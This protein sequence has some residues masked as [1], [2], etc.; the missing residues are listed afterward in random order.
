MT[1]LT[2]A[3]ESTFENRKNDWRIGAMTYQIFVDRFAPARDLSAKKHLY[4]SPK[5][6][7]DWSESP[8][9]E[10]PSD[11]SILWT[12]ELAFWGGDLNSLTHKLDY[13]ESLGMDVVYLN[14]IV[15]AQS[16]HK[17][18]AIDYFKIAPEYGD[19]DDLNQLTTELNKRDMHLILDGVFNH[20]GYQS[21]WFQSALKDENSP[22]RG[23]FTFNEKLP[24]GF[25]GWWG[26]K[27]LPELNWDNPEVK[28]TI[29][30]DENSVVRHY[31]KHGISGWRLDVASDLGFEHLAAITAASHEEMADS[32]VIGEVWAYPERWTQSMDAVM[33]YPLREL[34][35]LMV[36]NKLSGE[37]L[38]RQLESM[39][40]DAGIE[41]LLRSWLIIDNH[42]TARLKTLYPDE[43]QQ[44]LLQILQMTLP[45]AP[46]IYYGVELG[47]T[48]GED[49]GS[50]GP[51]RWDLNTEGN[52]QLSWLKNLIAIRQE[53]VAL[54][55]GDF[56]R[57]NSSKALAFMRTTDKVSDTVMVIV[58]SDDKPQS[59]YLMIRDS[60]I[61]A[62][63]IFKDALS[64]AE[65]KSHA[66]VLQITIPAQT[67]FI[68]RPKMWRQ[69]RNESGYSPY[70]NID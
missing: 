7:R 18:D 62:G 44:R 17:Y 12:H 55:I 66:G 43:K 64:G 9:Q 58:N 48:G 3:E 27:N 56:T 15:H 65:F 32:L 47:M 54:K 23:W 34:T 57:L 13:I 63:E 46:L 26:V 69:Y 68:L 1:Q 11:S 38:G 41:A 19:F 61:M 51:M 21:D 60:R 59:E 22:F 33:N 28:N 53:N 5:T 8:K 67:A 52:Q 31:F 20:V 45:G 4:P 40:N 49:P 42:D 36:E 14:P 39:I 6:L 24:N 29:V 35:F 50:R 30:S 2:A 70:K 25:V 37:Q 10:Q 16:N